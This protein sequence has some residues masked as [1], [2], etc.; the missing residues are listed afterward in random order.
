MLNYFCLVLPRLHFFFFLEVQFPE[1]CSV[2]LEFDVVSITGDGANAV[3]NPVKQFGVEA[4]DE[5]ETVV[6]GAEAGGVGEVVKST[7]E[8]LND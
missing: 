2:F 6:V 7:D 1:C 5:A 3:V 8:D 4:R